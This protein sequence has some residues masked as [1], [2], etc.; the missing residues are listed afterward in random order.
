MP[1]AGLWSL[2][3]IQTVCVLMETK[4][5]QG[6]EHLATYVTAVGHLTLVFLDVLQ[7][8]VQ[9][10]EHLAT[11]SHGAFKHL[12]VL[13]LYHMRF[14]VEVSLELAGAVLTDV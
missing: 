9:F 13:V 7:K 5:I 11:F 8:A 2:L 6:N 3:R 14:K 12:L 1:W 10:F 4:F